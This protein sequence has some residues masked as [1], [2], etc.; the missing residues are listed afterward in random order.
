[1]VA[2]KHSPNLPPLIPLMFLILIFNS[3]PVEAQQQC[4]V[5][6]D[7]SINGNQ[8]ARVDCGVKIAATVDSR[9]GSKV[10]INILF[11]NDTPDG[12]S[13]NVSDISAS[14]NEVPLEIFTADQVISQI[15]NLN[16]RHRILSGI[17]SIVDA[18]G[19]G[20]S[21]GRT[22]T[23]GT[24]SGYSSSG[25]YFN[26]IYSAT[27]T[28]EAARQREI[29]GVTNRSEAM[30]SN[31]S[32]SQRQ[33]VDLINNTYFHDSYLAPGE[34]TKGILLVKANTAN[35]PIVLEIAVGAER[36]HLTVF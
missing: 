20:M 15:T 28:D 26:G 10:A 36:A 30:Q 32:D 16:N 29:N 27:T 34:K 6:L 9:M 2:L 13:V 25:R 5:Q 31:I 1:M 24:V 22:T 8:I 4:V 21:A 14:Q 18:I 35:L 33:A 19:T 7:E 17:A 11:F 12:F 23:T 3:L